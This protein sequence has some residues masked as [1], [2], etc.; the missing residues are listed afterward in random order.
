[1]T[2]G[3]TVSGTGQAGASTEIVIG[4]STPSVLYF[5]VLFILVWDDGAVPDRFGTINVHDYWHLDRL[6]KQD[7]QYLNNQFS[8]QPVRR[9]S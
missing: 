7:R 4:T 8:F 9:W 1:M 5:C 3:V 2:T 6:S